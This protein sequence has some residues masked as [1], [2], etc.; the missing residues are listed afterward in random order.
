[1]YI[2]RYN[3][4]VIGGDLKKI[5]FID[6]FD[7]LDENGLPVYLS[8]EDYI[9][10]VYDYRYR[11]FN[12]EFYKEAKKLIPKVLQTVLVEIN[13]NGGEFS[14]TAIQL[15]N[16]TQRKYNHFLGNRKYETIMKDSSLSPRDKVM[17]LSSSFQLESKK[18]TFEEFYEENKGKTKWELNNSKQL[19]NRLLEIFQT[20]ITS[21]IHYV[22]S[23]VP[24]DFATDAL[25]VAVNFVD[26]HSNINNNFADL[27]PLFPYYQENIKTQNMGADAGIGPMALINVFRVV[28][29]IA[30]LKLNNGIDL[31]R[32]RGKKSSTRNLFRALGLDEHLYKKFD[33][34]GVP[35]L[36]WTS[37][38]INAHV[39][40]A[41]DSYIT[42][43]NVNAYTYDVVALLTCVG[44]GINQFYFLPQPILKEIAD[45][46]NRRASAKIG[47]TK[48]EKRSKKWMDNLI[49][50]Y[51][52]EAKIGDSFYK[53]LDSG[54]LQIEWNGETYYASDLIFNEDW[55]K[56]QLIAHHSGK[57]D[58]EWYRNQV[59]IYEYF[60]DIQSYSK[61]LS[62]LVLAAQV[63]TGKMGKNQA[64]LMLSMHNIERVMNDVHFLNAEDVFNN[65][66]LSRK[67]QNSTGLLFDLLQGEVLEF[68]AGFKYLV[69]LFGKLSNTYYD[70]KTNNINRYMSELKFAMQAEFFN[71]Y[72]RQNNV[73]LKEMFY[74][75]NT[76]VDRFNKIRNQILSG[77]KYPELA[78]NM[79]IKMLLPSITTESKPKHFETV[80]KMRDTDSKNAYTYAWRDLLEHSNKE[81]RDLAK[82]LI[83]YS[84]YTSGGRGTGIYATLDL[85]PYEVLGNLSYDKNGED[86]TYNQ[87]LKDLLNTANQN[88]LD[89]TT[90]LDYAFRALHDKEDIVQDVT[91]QRKQYVKGTPIYITLEAGEY[92]SSDNDKYVPFVKFSDRLFKLVGEFVDGDEIMPVYALT[93][94]I[95]YNESGFTINEG[96]ATTFIDDNKVEDYTDL[97]VPFETKFSGKNSGFRKISDP[98]LQEEIED[99]KYDSDEDVEG[100]DSVDNSSDESSSI[101]IYAGAGENVELSN[102]A[103]RPF[104][105]E[106]VD[107]TFG[108]DNRQKMFNSVE[109][110]FQYYKFLILEQAIGA[111]NYPASTGDYDDLRISKKSNRELLLRMAQE[112]MESKTASGAR[113]IGRKKLNL[114]PFISTRK[115]PQGEILKTEKVSAKEIETAIFKMWDSTSSALMKELIFA[116]FNQNPDAAKKLLATGNATLTHT[117]DK[118]KWGTEFPR[119]LMEVREELRNL[120]ELTK[121][122]EQRKNECK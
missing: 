19:E 117:Q 106:P 38:L 33:N 53:D 5:E 37:A 49:G 12:T 63:D 118:S 21:D 67:L 110:A 64:E 36:D 58:Q 60:R 25:K 6:D 89:Y 113:K 16:S 17:R 73:S 29:Q 122:G 108:D 34:N 115:T 71:E 92:M 23:T 68:T 97:S 20:T 104:T 75:D 52:K 14:E 90:Y 88:M 15:L 54:N 93:N 116:S 105:F 112:V 84:F 10:K 101:N 95:N 57:V 35:I 76:I 91:P 28:M 22:D 100:D 45:E 39:D 85:V 11:W 61:S 114:T 30:D 74:G 42:R 47:L 81:I 51:A 99:I 24:L 70:R 119:I 120:D 40:A 3:Y 79:L 46:A 78:D 80:L 56:E 27:E 98:F 26:A 32:R 107:Y 65:T 66:F 50:R 96:K 48:K 31:R 94:T 18:K 59:I 103:K 8:E 87:H 109:Q 13:K 62:N 111:L 55:L 72:C 43:L 121:L 9:K 77:S 69:N 83:V 1:M 4:E 7:K 2:A 44:V 41:K 86:Y 102:F 82:D